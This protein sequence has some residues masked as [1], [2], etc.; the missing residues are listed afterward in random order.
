MNGWLWAA[1]A[2]AAALVPLLLV[3]ALGDAQQGLVASEAAGIDAA[4]ALLL[5]AEG[6]QSQSFASLA[7]AAAVMS[8]IGSLAY[9]RFLGEFGDEP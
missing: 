8:F 5:F 7:L 1:T 9:I 2:L 6:T 3:A 4:L